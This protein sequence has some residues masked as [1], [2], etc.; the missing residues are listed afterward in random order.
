MLW[1]TQSGYLTNNKLNLDFQ[2]AAQPL[3]KFRQF[4][5]FKEAFGKQKGQS[6]NWLKVANAG[7]YGGVLTETN[8]M[9]EATLALS[10]GTLTV[11]EYGW[12]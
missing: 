11:G 3:M 12:N 10:W 1:S 4:T 6:V 5:Q 8:T 9:H 7:S 2:R